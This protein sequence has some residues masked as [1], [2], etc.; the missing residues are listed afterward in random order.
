MKIKKLTLLLFSFLALNGC[1]EST[2]FLGPAISIGTSGNVYQTGLSYASNKIVYNAT[3]QTTIEHV[4]AFLDPK[5]EF[6]GDLSLILMDNMKDV[7]EVLKKPKEKL[8][9]KEKKKI[10][11]ISNLVLEDQFILF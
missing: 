7:K 10:E 3:G 11:P 2:A 6:E 8:A 5:D 1:I 4:A 9:L